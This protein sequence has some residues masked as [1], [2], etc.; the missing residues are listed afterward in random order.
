MY[1][2]K[3]RK[4]WVS[5]GA[6]ERVTHMIYAPSCILYVFFSSKK[7]H[8]DCVRWRTVCLKKAA[9]YEIVCIICQSPKCMC[10][11]RRKLGKLRSSSNLKSA[12]DFYWTFEPWQQSNHLFFFLASRAN[13]CNEVWSNTWCVLRSSG[14][15]CRGRNTPWATQGREKIVTS[16]NHQMLIWSTNN[17]E[18]SSNFLFLTWNWK[19]SR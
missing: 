12:F 6:A 18:F 5:A 2:T 9:H 8:T 13:S 19:I 10:I 17:G 3:W 15:Q 16:A 7:R 4:N 11:W 1:S 14:T